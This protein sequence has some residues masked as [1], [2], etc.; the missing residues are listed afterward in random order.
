MLSAQMRPN[1]DRLALLFGFLPCR[2]WFRSRSRLRLYAYDCQRFG[3]ATGDVD[4]RGPSLVP[5]ALAIRQSAFTGPR[6]PILYLDK[7]HPRALL[8]SACCSGFP[9]DSYQE[10]R[11]PVPDLGE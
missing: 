3:N 11:A 9:V 8:A 5:F 1:S 7:P 2:P 6:L 10:V 4:G